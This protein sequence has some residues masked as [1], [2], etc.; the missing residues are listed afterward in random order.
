MYAEGE[1]AVE[2]LES[3][4]F[5]KYKIIHIQG[6]K[7]SSAQ[8]GRSYPLEDM[9]HREFN[10]RI[11]VQES[12]N[13]NQ[14]QAKKI[15]QDA[16]DYGSTFNVIYSENDDMTK[17]AVEALDEAGISHGPDGD[18]AIISF[19]CN[20]WAMAEVIKGSWNYDGQCNPY[21]ATY[22]D[23][24]IKTLESGG[25]LANKKI[26]LKEKSFSTDTIKASDIDDFGI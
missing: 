21:Q 18:V 11:A 22:I 17:G 8:K 5:K 7:G 9:V 10:W 1:A 2:Y 3:L 25:R 24:I 26:I 16:L 20:R 6:A 12:A 19:D 4:K 13:W 14:E 15:V 23:E